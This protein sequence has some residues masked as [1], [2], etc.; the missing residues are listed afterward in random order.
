MK[1][2]E[3]LGDRVVF[4]EGIYDTRELAKFYSLCSMVVFPG[5]ATIATSFAMC[6]AKPMVSSQYGNEVEYICDGINGFV[7]EYGSVERLAQKLVAL[8]QDRELRERFGSASQR[9]AIEQVNIEHLV[10]TIRRAA[11]FV[12]SNQ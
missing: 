8:L 9:L 5:Y 3:E 6:F 10:S 11:R 12:T 2:A 1:L 7:Y 4:H